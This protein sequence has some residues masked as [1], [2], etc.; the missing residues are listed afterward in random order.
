MKTLLL[1][2]LVTW[3]VISATLQEA[4]AKR[5][6]LEEVRKEKADANLGRK[7]NFGANDVEVVSEI[8]VS[9]GSTK[10]KTESEGDDDLNDTYNLAKNDSSSSST[11]GS[12]Y[13]PC[14]DSRRKNCKG[15]WVNS[16]D[17][18]TESVAKKE[19]IEAEDDTDDTISKCY[20]LSDRNR[21]FNGSHKPPPC[22]RYEIDV[23]DLAENKAAG[24]TE[25]K[26]KIE[27]QDDKKDTFSKGDSDT[28]D[29]IT[30]GDSYANGHRSFPTETL[31]QRTKTP[32][33]NG[34]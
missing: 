29:T 3:V 26:N 33:K 8:K 31:F 15:Q 30:K 22:R 5:L 23:K 6:T 10:K 14:D 18:A 27:A 28:I 34:L 24:S 7:V 32:T 11:F 13:V 4:D 9:T 17:K 16:E 12:H 25:E 1:V 19:K 2:L 21:S 20:S